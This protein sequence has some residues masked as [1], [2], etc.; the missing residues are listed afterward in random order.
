MTRYRGAVNIMASTASDAV[1]FWRRVLTALNGTSVIWAV[2]LALVAAL[3]ISPIFQP[4]LPVLLGRTLF[5]ALVVLL[6][7][8]A[9]GQWHQQRMPRW[10]LQVA[11]VVISAPLATL[12]VYAL[13]TGGDLASL[14]GNMAYVNGI[15]ILG[16][17][18]LLLGLV[19]G[20][21]ALYRER[22]AQ[23]D[24]AALTFALERETLQRQAADARLALLQSQVEPHFLFNTLANVQ[25]LVESGSPRA[26]PVLSSLIAYLRAAMP[27]L[28]EGA[29]TLGREEA[30]VRAYLDLM[31]MRMPDRLRFAVSIDPA[32][33]GLRLPP[34]TL[35]TLVENAV[36]HGID[37]SEVGGSIEV[38]AQR[39]TATGRIRLWVEDT[40]R[41]LDE[42]RDPGTG[43][44]NLR[45][46]L[47]AAFG[48]Q[49]R[50]S[51][52]AV[53]PSGVRAQIDLPA[54]V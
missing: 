2:T 27:Q 9:A 40:G 20:L 54:D 43:L 7:Y 25:A 1:P 52:S 8:T 47:A 34:M 29:P 49:A 11:A 23:A 50:L 10:Q 24:A 41:G 31:H 35:L 4:P 5:I 33:A 53:A 39:D 14:F 38:G 6:S 36:R 17:S 46:R 12:A 44:S 19:I 3:A 45:A 16:S 48:P 42:T 26:A 22:D 37:P 15:V 28:H 13:G 21:G 30:L 18:A 51:L 32:L